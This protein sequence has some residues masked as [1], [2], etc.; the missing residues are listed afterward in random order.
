VTRRLTIE[1]TKKKAKEGVRPVDRELRRTGVEKA[2]P[3]GGKATKIRGEKNS[4]NSGA[5]KAQTGGDVK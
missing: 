1:G 4:R 2:P 5:R 3:S